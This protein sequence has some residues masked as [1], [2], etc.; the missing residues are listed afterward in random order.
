MRNKFVYSLRLEVF[1]EN[2]GDVLEDA[3]GNVRLVHRIYVHVRDAVRVKVDDL[4]ACVDDAGLLHGFGIAAEFVDE[5]LESL[6][7]E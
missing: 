4:V 7:H 5:R 3:F 1:S 2:C 6:W